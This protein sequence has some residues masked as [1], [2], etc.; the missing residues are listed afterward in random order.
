MNQDN[1]QPST[2]PPQGLPANQ[3]EGRPPARRPSKKI[4]G[5][6]AG[7]IIALA[8]VVGALALG[9][10]R[11]SSSD[12][13]APQPRT[14]DYVELMEELNQL[15]ILNASE[16]FQ[17]WIF[18]DDPGSDPIPDRVDKILA[19]EKKVLGLIDDM[20]TMTAVKGDKAVGD[21][22]KKL[23]VDKKPDYSQRIQAGIEN[24]QV[25]NPLVVE[26]SQ[27][28]RPESSGQAQL[29][30]VK[31]LLQQSRSASVQHEVNQAVVE[32]LI[33]AL[34]TEESFLQDIARAEAS[35]GDARG[36]WSNLEQY[37]S[38]SVISIANLNNEAYKYFTT[39]PFVDAITPMNNLI[40]ERS[41][42]A[43]SVL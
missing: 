32:K 11:D 3:S 10:N 21:E 26:F 40:I 30:R 29:S 19:Q 5:I 22:F 12:L 43:Q 37:H 17:L 38:V 20:S 7:G 36:V 1:N 15:T 25:I 8:I 34:E 41:K 14:E 9:N 31:E 42:D 16:M 18:P 33:E 13:V 35:G 6:V 39:D 2:T 28:Y 24:Y 23:F 27:P 4:L